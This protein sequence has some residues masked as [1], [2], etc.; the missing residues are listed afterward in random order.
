MEGKSWYLS[1]TVWGAAAVVLGL[2]SP[3]VLHWFGATPDEASVVLVA[4]ASAVADVVGLVLV[5]IGR[6]KAQGPLTK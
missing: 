4:L 2:V 1:R 5:I 6:A 3:T